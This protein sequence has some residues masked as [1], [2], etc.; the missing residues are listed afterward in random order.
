M[1]AGSNK[2]S[3]WVALTVVAC[4]ALLAAGW[5]LLIS[6]KRAE[7]A[8][9]REQAEGQLTSNDSTRAQIQVLKAKSKDLP[10]KQAELAKVAARIPDN[11][12]LPSL[13][14]ALTAASTSA[15]VEF[16][17]VAPGAPVP[18]LA[19]APAAAPAPSTDGSAAPPAAPAPAGGAA[20]TLASIPLTLNVVGDYFEIEQFVANLE[21]LP[22][23]LRLTNL[24][25]TP[26]DSPTKKQSSEAA[27][28]PDGSSL[29]T[30]LTGAVFMA[31]S[32]ALPAAGS[33]AAPAPA[34]AVPA[35]ATA[36]SPAPAN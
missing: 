18:V 5:F 2:V 36:P 8:D 7:A 22:R 16:V 34:A 4:L 31:T 28:E 21:A 29:T 1:N 12:S 9:L 24:S 25:V 14:R 26:G 20:G 13:V 15:G 6:P 11:P 23:A 10:K 30:T 27:G 17:S 19:A 35:P 33:A 32:R 3:Q